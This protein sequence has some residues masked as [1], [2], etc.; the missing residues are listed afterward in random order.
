MA[1]EE[2]QKLTAAEIKEM[3]VKQH[4]EIDKRE[5][6][7]I[8]RRVAIAQADSALAIL[9]DDQYEITSRSANAI[10]DW[11]AELRAMI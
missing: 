5:A 8:W 11:S 6:G 10:R 3:V 2:K 1:E 4:G 9:E 7:W